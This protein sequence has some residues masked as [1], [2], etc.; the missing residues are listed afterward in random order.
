MKDFL[1]RIIKFFWHFQSAYGLITMP[2][3]GVSASFT[4]FT[5]LDVRYHIEFSGIQY[6]LFYV[7]VMTIGAGI[8]LIMKNMGLFKYTTQLGNEQNETVMKINEILQKL[9]GR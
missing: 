5:F 7:V 8:G 2:L 1:K 6:I 9:D 4:L 3:S